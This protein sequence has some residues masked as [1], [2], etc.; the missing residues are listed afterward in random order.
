MS[1][2]TIAETVQLWINTKAVS[3]KYPTLILK[4]PSVRAKTRGA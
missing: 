3:D 4:I 1:K 2:L